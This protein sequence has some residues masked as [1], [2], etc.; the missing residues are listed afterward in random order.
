MQLTGEIVTFFIFAHVFVRSVGVFVSPYYRPMRPY[1]LSVLF[2]KM[3]YFK[4]SV[5]MSRP[6][7]ALNHSQCYD[8]KKLRGTSGCDLEE[9]LKIV[10]KALFRC[11]TM[12]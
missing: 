8:E 2:I 5:R 12:F 10:N 9:P 1:L 11:R 6:P 4:L 7:I 3:R